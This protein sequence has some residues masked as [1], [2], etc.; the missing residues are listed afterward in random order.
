MMNAV[1][2]EDE[3]YAALLRRDRACD[4]MFFYSVRTTGEFCRPSCAARPPRREN[5]GFHASVAAAERAGF[6]AC[7]R[8]RP[9]EPDQASRHEAAIAR[10]CRL[11]ETAEAAPKLADLAQA[12]GMS[13][14][15]FHR[16]FRQATGVTPRAFAA[17]SRAARVRA[18]LGQ[19][20]TVTR[21]IYE[22]GYNAP[23]RFYAEAPAR[24][25]MTPS[26]WRAGGAGV[27]IRFALGACALGAILVAATEKG[28]CAIELGDDP[29][30]LLRGLQD[31]FPR[32][33]LVGA[34][35]GFEQMVA[36][37]VGL[38]EAPGR[39]PAVKLDIGG[40]AFQQRVWQALQAIPP[41]QTASYT[42]VAASIGAP[43]SARAVARAC[44]SNA[45][46]VAI[47]CHRV[48]RSDGGLSG[49]RWGIARKRAL[50]ASEAG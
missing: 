27:R 35:A 16:V 18:Q 39:A 15:H 12:A 34:D 36:A 13:A 28:V 3:K 9:A 26:A 45:L 14:F 43:R 22:A 23:S 24:L 40:T 6:R 41:G 2:T 32:A 30:A 31:R 49:Y 33:E 4:G 47:P 37:V 46:A 7:K 29:E 20:G 17:A 11:I 44:A 38:M 5:V 42:Q 19:A 8:C 1:M 48:V 10:A 25:G 21:A 50:L